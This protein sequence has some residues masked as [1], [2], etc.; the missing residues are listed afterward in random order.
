[1]EKKQINF[2]SCCSNTVDITQPEEIAARGGFM[3][4]GSDNLFP[5]TLIG[6]FEDCSIL[7]TCVNSI[8]DYIAGNGVDNDVVINRE[9]EL[10]SELIQRIVFDYILTGNATVQII[11]NKNQRLQNYTI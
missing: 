4:W 8:T 7:A 5:E 9:G 6:C 10:L 3:Q 1:M 2:K 11:R